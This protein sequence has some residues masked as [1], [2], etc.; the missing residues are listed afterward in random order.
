VPNYEG[1]TV[2]ERLFA[3]GLMDAFDRAAERNDSLELKRILKE[4]ALS[5]ANIEGVL[6][7][8]AHSP[9]SRFNRAPV[10]LG[11][12]LLADARVGA[13]QPQEQ[14]VVQHLFETYGGSSA[15]SCARSGCGQRALVRLAYCAYCAHAFAG[16]R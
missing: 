3:A 14:R 12:E 15:A 2:N 11:P 1:M 7:W 4:V 16:V 6:D 9:Y 5:D 13:L 8:L 10:V